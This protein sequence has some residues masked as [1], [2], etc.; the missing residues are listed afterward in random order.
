MPNAE[1]DQKGL[2]WAY[3]RRS[4]GPGTVYLRGGAEIPL[5]ALFPKKVHT[6]YR[7]PVSKTNRI[8][9]KV[10]TKYQI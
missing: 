10:A 8:Q 6:K 1:S 4:R 9:E 7:N 2:A 3:L 5:M